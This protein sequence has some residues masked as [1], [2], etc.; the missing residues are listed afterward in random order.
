MTPI[1]SNEDGQ[2]RW[3]SALMDNYGTPKLTLVRGEG[4]TVWDADGKSYVDLLGGI[5]V[6]DGMISIN[7][8]IALAVGTGSQITVAYPFNF[9]LLNPV[10]KMVVAD[11]K[12]GEALTI[13]AVALMR[14]EGS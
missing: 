1:K 13:S 6:N 5:A 9:M 12:T 10:A 8:S 14:N 3:R 2:A 7:N 11:S 4:A